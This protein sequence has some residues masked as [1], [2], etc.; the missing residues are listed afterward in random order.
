MDSMEQKKQIDERIERLEQRI[1]ERY[2]VAFRVL[3]KNC[4][5]ARENE[6][7]MLTRLAWKNAIVIEHAETE[8]AARKNMFEDGDLLYMYEM[9]E[10][11]MLNAI[12]KEI[13]IQ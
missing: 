8:E 4:F 3:G 10:E 6:F 1:R 11:N 13:E 5:K 12:V 7:F 9:N 2:E